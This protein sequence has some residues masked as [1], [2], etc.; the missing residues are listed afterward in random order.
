MVHKHKYNT[1]LVIFIIGFVISTILTLTPTPV[2]CDGSNGCEVVQTS[3][4]AYLFGVKVATYGIGIF[5]LLILITLMHMK[6]PKNHT[7]HII[8]T[9]VILGAA[10]SLYFIYL[11][12][13]VL[14]AYCKYC[15]IVD[16]SILIGLIIAILYWKH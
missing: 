11:Q 1:L 8:H 5:L 7:R 4:Y 6:T 10:V 9:G 12:K 3:S 16:V 13:Y 15:M 2:I 14:Q